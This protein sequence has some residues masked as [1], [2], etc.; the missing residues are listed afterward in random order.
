M[1][2]FEWL[3]L[4]LVGST[5]FCTKGCLL[6]TSSCGTGRHE[7]LKYNSLPDTFY[8]K[9][10]DI[11]AYFQPSLDASLLNHEQKEVLS[12]KILTIGEW[13][14]VFQ[15]IS[16]ETPPSW[17]PP[18]TVQPPQAPTNPGDCSALPLLKSLGILSPTKG[19]GAVFDFQPSLSFDSLDSSAICTPENEETSCSWRDQVLPLALLCY[20]DG[21]G[22]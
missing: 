13:F 8:V 10:N 17:F 4:G 3:C 20:V 15:N 22:Q 6:G 2:K 16:S 21:L 19:D 7:T 14:E 18:L 12:Q 9:Y 11:Q 1:T 5:K